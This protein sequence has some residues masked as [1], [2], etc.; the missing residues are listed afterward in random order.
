M[1]KKISLDTTDKGGGVTDAIGPAVILVRLH[2]GNFQ[3]TAAKD[4]GSDLRF[5][6]ADDKTLL[7]YHIEKYDALLNEVFVWV[8]VPYL[9]PGSLSNIWL[10]YGNSSNKATKADDVKATYDSDTVLVYHFEEKGAP[11]NDSS[12]NGNNSLTAGLPTDESMIG[13]GFRFDGKSTIAIPASPSLAWTA[14]GTMTWSAWIKPAILQSNAIVYSRHQGANSYLIGVDNGVPYVEVN[15]QRS[16]AGAA[17]AINSWRHLAVV[18]AGANYTLSGWRDLLDLK[19]AASRIGL[20]GPTRWRY[21]RGRN[22]FHRRAGRTTNLPRRAAG[23][24]H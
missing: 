17:L 5:V 8:K 23:R 11:P 4:D 15:G 22:W 16:N 7:K 13:G 9:K 2:D 21:F 14:S 12:G 1:R 10:Y 3:F 24:L 19:R 20:C 6:S 18:A